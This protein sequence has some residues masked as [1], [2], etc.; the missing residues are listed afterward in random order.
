ME[1]PTNFG[2]VFLFSFGSKYFKI[3]LE[4]YLTHMLFRSVLFNFQT[5]GD[6]SANSLLL[7]SSLVPLWSD[8]ILC[9]VFRLLNL[10]RCVLWTRM[11]S[12]LVNVPCELEYVF[13]CCWM[14]FSINV[15]LIILS[16]SAVQ[17]NYI[18]A[19]ILPASAISD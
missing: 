10:L 4:T 9:V 7:I 5:F 3:S 16:D 12:I 8:N 1:H 11:W 18:F 17:V 15:N 19:V 14:K 13:C 6:L 2:G